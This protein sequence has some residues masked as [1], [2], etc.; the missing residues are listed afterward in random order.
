VNA[1][2]AANAWAALPDAITAA[3]FALVWAS[4]LAFGG[5]SVKTAMLT[6]L[7]EFFLVHA[8]GFFTAFANT[9]RASK[10]KR[11][12]FLL[13]LSLFYVLMIGA[14]SW[15]FGEWWPLLG[16]GWLLVGK[17]WWIRAHPVADDDA[18]FWQMGAWAASVAAYL[19]GC[20]LTVVANIPRW[21]MTTELQPQFGLSG[22]GLWIDEPHRVVAF[23]VV[24]F[25]LLAVGKLLA[26]M[27]ATRKQA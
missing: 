2:R 7:L 24:Y 16:F 13:G 8:T 22:G 19:F 12:A 9:P 3:M 1:T 17:I 15:S 11:I 18:M 10:G 6:M 20:G 25:G 26:A 4:P 5:L 14:F 27:W 23:G 21:G